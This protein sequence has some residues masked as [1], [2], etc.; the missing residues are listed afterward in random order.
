MRCFIGLWP[1]DEAV[2]RLRELPR[3][4]VPG[5]RW[6][7]ADQW[8]VTLRFLGD[9]D[10]A[11]VADVGERLRGA[12]AGERAA[13]LAAGPVTA[14]LGRS[15]LCLP[16]DGADGLAAR[17]RA[18]TADV[19]E[20]PT[21]PFR[22]HLTLARSRRGIPSAVRDQPFEVSWPAMSVALIGSRLDPA[23]ARYTTVLEVP[24]LA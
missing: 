8:H 17:V 16:V 22:G 4:A 7:T 24:L 1:D 20:P 11:A 18:A 15:V 5:L 21:A 23:G 19:G 6:T 9:L 13:Q 3:A 12:L 2:A 10:A 14:V